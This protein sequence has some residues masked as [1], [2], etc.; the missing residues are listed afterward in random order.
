LAAAIGRSWPLWALLLSHLAAVFVANFFDPAARG[1][2]ADHY[3]EE[4]R[5]AAYSLLRVAVNFGWAVGPACG[6]FLAEAAYHRLFLWSALTCAL[7]AGG[8]L[9]WVRDRAISRAGAFEF[10]GVLEAGKDPALMRLCV[11]G[12]LISVAMSQLVV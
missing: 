8:I 9:L 12:M 7:S 11:F 1:W 4:E 5:P 6:G 2:V 3:D 10:R